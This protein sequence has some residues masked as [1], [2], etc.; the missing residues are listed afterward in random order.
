[1]RELATIRKID[2]IR[3]IVG[4][5]AIEAAVLGGWVV[6]VKKGEYQP[7]DLAIYCE[8]DSWVPH[9]LAPFLSKGNEPREFNGV[10]GERLRSVKLRGQISQG[11]LLPVTT[12]IGGFTFI[13]DSAGET[14]I[15]NEGDNVTDAL[16][17]Q[18]WEAPISPQ[19]AG[20]VQGAFPGY[21]PKTDEERI[22][23]LTC[24]FIG[25]KAQNLTWEVSEKLEGSSMTVYVRDEDQG[26][27]S[28]NLD[29]KRNPNN[30]LW[31][32]A[33]RDQLIE[34][35]RSTGRNL[36]LQGELIGPGIQDNIYKLKAHEFRVYKIY[37]I[38]AGEFLQ[39]A[40]RREMC[41]TLGIDHVPV[42]A[43]AHVF[44]DADT[45]ESVIA[46]ADAKSV[47]GDINGPLR[48][49]IVYKCNE[50]KGVSFKAIS[51]AYLIKY[52]H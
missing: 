47:M 39:P 35:I 28:R 45:Q 7:G 34:K 51:N 17:I 29:L 26:V 1:M 40:E 52:G 43:T 4:A 36:A 24:E 22:Q 37:D 30:T 25:W 27:C 2:S 19:L 49:G 6:V 9:T 41:K 50:L 8:I 11:L 42:F 48:E 31:A 32:V 15:V 18:K 21:I 13:K 44:T 20:E 46:A 33:I 14:L 23:N 12:G 38:D 5:D 10:K 3:P 16:G